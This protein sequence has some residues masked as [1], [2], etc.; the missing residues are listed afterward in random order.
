MPLTFSNPADYELFEENDRVSLTDL[1]SL[2]PRKFVLAELQKPDGRS[3][4]LELRH[5]LT[6]EQIQWFR[7]GS[8]LNV[9]R[10]GLMNHPL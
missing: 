9:A 7:A 1:Q 5:S 6:S 10:M 3:I 2:A 8:A 4:R